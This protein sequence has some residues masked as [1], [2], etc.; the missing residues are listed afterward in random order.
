MRKD[1]AAEAIEDG[2]WCNC[3]GKGHGGAKRV[4]VDAFYAQLRARLG[5]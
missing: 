4:H 1:C 5:V 3:E 2:G